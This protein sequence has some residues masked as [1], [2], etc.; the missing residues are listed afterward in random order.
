MAL[1]AREFKSGL[2]AALI[3]DNTYVYNATVSGPGAFYC[4]EHPFGQRHDGH[5]G[6]SN[7]PILP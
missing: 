1:K 7:G 3:F 2:R 6:N 4:V 5:Q